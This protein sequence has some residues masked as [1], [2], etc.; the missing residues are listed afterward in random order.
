MIMTTI[1][2]SIYGNTNSREKWF[3]IMKD[4]SVMVFETLLKYA[5]WH[6]R[7]SRE[8]KNN[9]DKVYTTLNEKDCIKLKELNLI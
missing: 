1:Y 9:I 8:E 7:A 2:G 6:E 3:A 5:G 4:G